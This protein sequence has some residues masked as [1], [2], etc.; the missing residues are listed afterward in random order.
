[1]YPIYFKC[2][3]FQ[4][5]DGK[6]DCS[7]LSDE[8]PMTSN[9]RSEVLFSSRFQLIANPILRKLVW[10]M[11]VLALI[12]NIVSN[13]LLLFFVLKFS[14]IF[15]KVSSDSFCSADNLD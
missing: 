6:G 11:G 2:L 14:T 8:C 15:E 3:F 10:F 12:G 7:D 5:F 4:I 13:H 9:K 1:M